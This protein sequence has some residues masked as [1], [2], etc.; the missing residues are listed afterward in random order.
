MARPHI[1]LAPASAGKT[2]FALA[3]A[4]EASRGLAGEVRLVVPGRQQV[5]SCRRRLAES[6]GALGVRVMTFDELNA[7]CLVAAGDSYKVLRP[8]VQYGLMRSVAASTAP[9]FYG[10]VTGK[11]GFIEILLAFAAELKAGR[12]WPETFLDAVSAMGGEPR[13]RELGLIYQAYQTRLDQE[14]WA[15]YAGLAWLAVERLEAKSDVATDWPLLILD[16]FASFTQVQYDL[17]KVLAARAG[18]TVITLTGAGGDGQ[19]RR[20]FRRFQKTCRQLEEILGVVAEALPVQSQQRAPALRHLAAYL[21]EDAPGRTPAAGQVILVQAPNRAGEVR[22]ALRWLKERLVWEGMQPGEVALL[23][24]DLVPYRPFIQQTAAEFGLPIQ[25]TEGLPLRESPIVK[26]LMDLLSLVLPEDGQESYSPA[27]PRK[28]VIAAWRS[29]YFDWASAYPD[30]DSDEPIG[31]TPADADALDAVARWGRVIAGLGQWQEVMEGLAGRASGAG[32]DD[33]QA[34][35]LNVL[36]GQA[37][38]DL[39][40]KLTRFLRRILPPLGLGRQREYIRWLENLIGDDPGAASKAADPTSLK[41]TERMAQDGTPLAGME[42]AALNALKDVLRGLLWLEEQVGGGKLASFDEFYQELAGAVEAAVFHPQT[43]PG[44]DEILVASL[45]IARGLPFKAA[46]V[47]G[48]AEGEFPTTLAEDV[49]L[50]EADRDVLREDH[51]LALDSAIESSE[52]E[53]FYE[54][55][56]A[57]SEKLLLTRPNLAESGAEWPASPFWEEISRLL[58]VEPVETKT[59]SIIAPDRAA[60]LAELMESL[61]DNPA[62]QAPATWLRS[63]DPERWARL[64]QAGRTFGYRFRGAPS[65]YNGDLTAR[66]PAFADRFKADHAWSPS[67][68]ETYLGCPLRFFVGRVLGLEPRIEPA[69]GLDVRQ[70][71]SIYHEI[72]EMLYGSVAEEE[73]NNPQALLDALPAVAGP[74][75]DAAPARQGFRET[76]W[77]QQTRDE[78]AQNIARSV[79]ALA[80]MAGQWTPLYFEQRFFGKLSL[81]VH[82]GEDSFRLH[83]VIDRVDRDPAGRLRVIDYKTAGP[84]SYGKRALEHGDK[85]QLPLYSLAA[86]DALALGEPADGFYWHIRQAEPSELQL[87]DYGPEEAIEMA[88]GHAWGAVHGARQGH[89]GPTPPSDGCPAYCPAVDFCWQYRGGW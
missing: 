74:I 41:V 37:A 23:A 50:P 69:E 88:L 77:W 36:S 52:R 16:G 22:E 81:V 70:L 17:L 19:G 27:L 60:S 21:F 86:R 57:A 25:L 80:G 59:D 2:A 15:D 55:I 61:V 79:Q 38:Q 47:L 24:R 54:A 3:K 53:Y 68:L 89:F 40:E 82:D 9:L 84:Y 1:Y 62:H 46:A 26:A 58:D 4:R 63:A 42:V 32:L 78:M 75:L 48:L 66:G 10:K 11:P 18:E 29:P 71:G 73:R 85:I 56:T 13:L 34:L 83:G 72:F 64:A 31:I 67:S 65:I 7:E 76:A 87:A 8:V 33:E 49:F 39:Q 14:G 30:K 20:V 45:P 43:R 28:G 12:I 44:R 6:G 51:Q 5:L 35:P